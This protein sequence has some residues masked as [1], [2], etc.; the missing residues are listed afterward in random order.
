M[1]GSISLRPTTPEDETFLLTLYASTRESELGVLAWDERLTQAFINMQFGA[2]MQ[3]YRMSY[4]NASNSIVLLND[5]PVGRLIVDRS[6]RE[7]I[8]VDISLIPEQRGGG[9]GT[10][11]IKELL[12]EA[13]STTKPVR[14]HVLRTNRAKDLYERLGFAVVNSDEL[15]CEMIAPPGQNKSTAA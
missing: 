6:E 1:L 7:L 15:Y 3:Q 9:I 2:Q 5:Q 10:H 12:F 11:L 13:S 14:L 4:A 8:L